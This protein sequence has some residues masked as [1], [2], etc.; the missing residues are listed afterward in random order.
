MKKYILYNP[1]AG[2]EQGAASAKKLDALYIGQELIYLDMTEISDY[3]EFFS[4]LSD[5]DDIIVCG[6]DGTLNRFINAIEAIEINN[7]IM[8]YATGSGNDFLHDLD[9]PNGSEPFRINEYI[10]DLPYMYID[11]EKR[12]FINGIGYGL[13]GHVCEMVNNLKKKNQNSYMLC[14]IKAILFSFRP[15]NATVT[16]DGVSK[17]YTKVWLSPTMKGRYF[18]GGMMVAPER[19]RK[20]KDLSVVVVHDCGKLR[21]LRIL[22][23]VFKGTHIKFK[24]YI[25]THH[26][27]EVTIEYDSPCAVQ[28][29]GETVLGV[30]SYTARAASRAAAIVR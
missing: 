10:Q 5:D 12:R 1:I 4:S 13:D 18:G 6:G 19:N 27:K 11:D 29:D 3:R 2:D 21:L 25:E 22:P 16:I 28:I 9:K 24:K 23:T 17:H 30:K 15:R 26:A 7:S 14:A 8:Y 20:Q